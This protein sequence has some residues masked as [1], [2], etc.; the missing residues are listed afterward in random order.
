MTAIIIEDEIPSGRRL[1]RLLVAKDVSVLSILNSV[2]ESVYW[3]K[4][5]NHPDL[6]FMDIKLRDD[7][8][9]KIFDKVE[10]QS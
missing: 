1:G 7:L 4:N 6:V 3:F 2:N 5:N 10:I 8:C 9:F